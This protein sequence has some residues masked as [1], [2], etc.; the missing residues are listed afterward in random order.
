MKNIVKTPL[1]VVYLNDGFGLS[2]EDNLNLCRTSQVWGVCYYDKISKANIFL[3]KT[4]GP[5]IALS[6]AYDWCY[7]AFEAEYLEKENITLY[8]GLPH[9]DEVMSL[10][11]GFARPVNETME[12]FRK[13]GIL[14]DNLFDEPYLVFSDEVFKNAALLH[15]RY[16]VDM[17]EKNSSN[18]FK[19]VSIG[20][21]AETVLKFTAA[22]FKKF[23]RYHTR[24]FLHCVS[25]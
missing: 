17:K 6:K 16:W 11:L 3:S 15:L 21:G 1:V 4:N 8:G 14:A 25:V 19:A 7:R 24:M 22:D 10:I 23:E 5:D 18:L 9:Y 2:L 13:H 12:I 20:D